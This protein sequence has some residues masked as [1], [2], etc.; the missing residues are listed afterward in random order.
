M[1]VRI[2]ENGMKFYSDAAKAAKNEKA[3]ELF[4]MLAD[5]EGGHIKAFKDLRKLIKEVPESAEPVFGET[6]M[7]LQA[8]ADAEVFTEAGKGKDFAAQIVNE[9]QVLRKAMDMEKDS[10]LFYYEMEKMI[11]E[12]DKHIVSEIILQ[13]KEHYWKLSEIFKTL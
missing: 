10:L 13:E 5:E 12:K 7:Y 3:R 4:K 11:R 1:A 6:T 8:M 9:K 2:E